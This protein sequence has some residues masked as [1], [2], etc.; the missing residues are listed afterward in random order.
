L[1]VNGTH[2]ALK[3][4]RGNIPIDEILKQVGEILYWGGF[5]AGGK[6]S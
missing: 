3:I 6:L 2:V 4:E 1:T 5:S